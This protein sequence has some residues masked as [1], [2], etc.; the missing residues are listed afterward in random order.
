MTKLTFSITTLLPTILSIAMFAADANQTFSGEIMDVQCGM[1]KSHDLMMKQKGSK[2]AVECTQAC[3]RDGGKVVLY[4]ST[5]QKVYQLADQE[6]AI[7]F[8]G[9]KVTVTGTF[10][11]GNNTLRVDNVQGSAQ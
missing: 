8:A 11:A 1:V 5:H 3:M 2:D 7:Q 6:K 10:D 4:D 9:Q